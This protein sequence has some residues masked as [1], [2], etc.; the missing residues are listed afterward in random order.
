MEY[1]YTIPGVPS[2]LNKF[3]G[4][5][6]SWDY[7]NE[8][9]EW[10][11]R[12]YACCMPRPSE[13]IKKAKVEISYHFPTGHRH[14]PDNYAG[15][16]ILDGLVEAGILQDDSFNNIELTVRKAGVDKKRPRTVVRIEEV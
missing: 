10:T 8:K 16:M 11:R 1:I 5:M 15:K 7:R 3:A 13:P 6:N 2:S 12:V 14:D 4:R 9:K